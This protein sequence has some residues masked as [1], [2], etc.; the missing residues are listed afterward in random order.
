MKV[1]DEIIY[2]GVNNHDIDLFEGQYIVPNGMAYNSY[3]IRDEKIAVMDT[4]D[5]AFGEEWLENVKN[6]LDGAKPEYLIIQHMEPDHSANIEK[7]MEVYPDTKIVGNA[8]TFTMISNFFRNL[9][10]EGKKVVVK[11]QEKLELGKHILTFVF[12]PMVHWPEVMVTYDSTDKVL[13]SA[14]GFGKFGALDVEE[15][16]D[17]EARRYYFGIVG[18]YGVQVQN[19]LKAASAL[20]IEK[21][22]PLHGPVLSENLEHY[23]GQYQ[24]WSSYGVE[25]EGV[26]IAYTSVY[27]NTKKAAELLGE[28]LKEKGCPKLWYVILPARICRSGRGCIPLWKAGA[29]HNHL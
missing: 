26:M 9:D 5:E 23:L 10:L 27:G 7:F 18:K 24:T 12:A 11:N 17:C 4:V 3:V 20:E 19:L 13:F 14:D 1:T 29:C 21:I 16:W 22:C 28:K 8:K 25:S 6:A 15:D 2:V